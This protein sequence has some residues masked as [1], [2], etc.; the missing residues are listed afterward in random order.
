MSDTIYPVSVLLF[1]QI[2]I[3]LI[4]LVAYI[5]IFGLDNLSVPLY[6][7]TYCGTGILIELK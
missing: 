2:H 1:S 7:G 4:F 6:I 3:I 5:G